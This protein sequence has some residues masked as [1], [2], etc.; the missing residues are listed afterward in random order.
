MPGVITLKCNFSESSL[1]FLDL[2]IMIV[3]GRLETEL[4]V[5]PT[6]L[7]LFLNYDSNHPTHCKDA[8]V[9][10]QALR[11]IE[12]CSQP[13][14]AE[15]HLEKLRE[16]FV[17][18]KYPEEIIE[19][20]FQ[21]ATSKNRKDLIFQPRKAAQKDDKIR[22]I[23]THNE[24]NPPLHKWIRQCKKLLKTPKAKELGSKFQLV[25]KQHTNL[26]AGG[27]G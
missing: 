9:Y 5:K 19:K 21:K 24:S 11:V 10:S 20:Q 2:R 23:F 22:L 3:N 17:E 8:I 6:N 7:Q 14:S 25:D 16:R 12:R 27:L 1:E 18:R 15:P 13:G 26:Q 4:F